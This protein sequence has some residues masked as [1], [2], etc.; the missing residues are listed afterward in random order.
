MSALDRAL[1]EFLELVPAHVRFALVGGV[2]VAART[3]PRFTRDL[4]FA[5]SVGTDQ[6]ADA[7]SGTFGGAD[8]D[9]TRQATRVSTLKRDMKAPTPIITWWLTH[10]AP[11]ASPAAQEWAAE[12][13]GEVAAK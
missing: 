7:V 13:V 4:D 2:A 9:A 10:I 3:E 8:P 6:E 11:L 5:I 1:Q 12:R